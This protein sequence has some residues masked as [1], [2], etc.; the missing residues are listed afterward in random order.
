MNETVEFLNQHL[1]RNP[2]GT[3][4]NRPLIFGTMQRQTNLSG[5][6]STLFGKLTSLQHLELDGTLLSGTIPSELGLLVDMVYLEISRIPALQGSLPTE[7]GLMTKLEE[8]YVY[9][10]PELIGT[11]PTELGSLS[12]L[13]ELQL[14]KCIFC[15]LI[16]ATFVV[17]TAY[18]WDGIVIIF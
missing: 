11:I 2:Q 7:F 6:I 8:L 12:S 15:R 4:Y 3:L 5:T 16:V 17:C 9:D 10:L 1:Q 14:R 18:R 13:F